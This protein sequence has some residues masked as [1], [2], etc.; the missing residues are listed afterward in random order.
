MIGT[1]LQNH[2]RLDAE[3]G[4]GVMSTDYQAHDIVL[5]RLNN[6]DGLG[7]DIKSP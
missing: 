3:L 4:H 2:Y 5:D 7:H 1:T 6:A